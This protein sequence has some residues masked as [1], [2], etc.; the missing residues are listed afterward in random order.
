MLITYMGLKSYNPTVKAPQVKADSELP[1][2]GTCKH[3]KLSF[4]WFR[5]GCCGRCFSCDDCHII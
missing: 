3:M 2:K 5:Y 4:R 1:N